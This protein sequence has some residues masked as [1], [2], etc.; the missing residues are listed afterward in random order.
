MPDSLSETNEVLGRLLSLMFGIDSRPYDTEQTLWSKVAKIRGV[1]V[2]PYDEL[3][4]ILLRILETNPSCGGSPCPPCPPCP[5]EE[6]EA[7]PTTSAFFQ[8]VGFSAA[9]N[10]F[11]SGVQSIT[12][13][14]DVMHGFYDFENCVDLTSVSFPNLTNI[15]TG[16]SFSYLWLSDSPLLATVLAPSLVEVRHVV[17]GAGALVLEN[18]ASLVSVSFPQLVTVSGSIRIHT[19]PAL[20]SISVPLWVPTNGTNHLFDGNALNT[21]SVNHILARLVASPTWGNAGETVDI[22]GGTN[23]APSGQGSTDKATLIAR[24]ATVTTN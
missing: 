17:M 20:V 14:S 8:T 16:T 22:S 19:S 2:S 9:S 5:E 12:I 10:P 21:A 3:D 23:A 15:G 4:T 24:G 6:I 18:L 11:L 13:K 7:T 1:R